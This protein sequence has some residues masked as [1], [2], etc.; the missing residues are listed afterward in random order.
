[1]AGLAE[2]VAPTAP[3]K[4]LS[5][6]PHEYRT[7]RT[8]EEQRTLLA[9][10]KSQT[11]FALSVQAGSEDPKRAA[12]LGLGFSFGGGTGWFVPTTGGQANDS[13]LRLFSE[14]L[15]NERIEKVGHDLKF[16]SSVLQWHG[17]AMRGKLFDIQLA[18][19]LIEPDM[20]H[21]LEYVAE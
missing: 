3:L 21:T 5:D 6:V 7:A 15:E 10:L 20:R 11:A 16:A 18:H 17:V 1:M 19:S 2:S 4:T 9:A 14:V 8:L 13:A 12:L